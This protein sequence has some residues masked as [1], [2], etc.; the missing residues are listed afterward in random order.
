[1]AERTCSRCGRQVDGDEPHG[2]CPSCLLQ[3]GLFDETLDR[4]ERTC[5]KC[6]ETLVQ[7]ARS[8]QP[9]P[10]GAIP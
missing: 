1:M 5:S 4:T 7:D 6:N 2:L 10:A 8:P 3:Q 9:S